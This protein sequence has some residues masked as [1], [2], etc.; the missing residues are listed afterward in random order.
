MNHVKEIAKSIIQEMEHLNH[1]TIPA[2]DRMVAAQTYKKFAI[3]DYANALRLVR[4]RT[5]EHNQ[6][7][8]EVAYVYYYKAIA[9]GIQEE[10][11]ENIFSGLRSYW[12]KKLADDGENNKVTRASK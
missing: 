6:R 11:L 12:A 2:S 10:R 3:M 7:C 4:E 9:L 8:I 5:E 1:E